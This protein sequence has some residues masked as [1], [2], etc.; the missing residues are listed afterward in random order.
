MAGV[1]VAVSLLSAAIAGWAYVQRN[2]AVAARDRALGLERAVFELNALSTE[3]LVHPNLRVRKQ[4]RQRHASL[5]ELVEAGPA[6][7]PIDP[8]TIREIRSRLQAMAGAF[9]LLSSLPSTVSDSLLVRSRRVLAGRLL[10]DSQA[11]VAIA[12]RYFIEIRQGAE[13][14]ERRLLLSLLALIAL[15]AVAFVISAMLIGR[16]VVR[17]VLQLSRSMSRM[18]EGDLEAP[19]ES[20]LGARNEVGA[21]IRE[22]DRTRIRLRDIL[23]QQTERVELLAHRDEELRRQTEELQRSNAELAQFAYVAS[24]DLRA[25]LR[26]INHLASW[27]ED[28]AGDNLPEKAKANLDL[29]KARVVRM[30]KLLTDLLAYSRAGR[31]AHDEEVVDT[32]ELVREAIEFADRPPGFTIDIAPGLPRIKTVRLPLLQVFGNL[33]SNAVKHHDRP[34]GRVEIGCRAEADGYVF[35]VADDGPGI[36]VADRERVFEMFRTL[37]RK[38]EV[39]GT[40]MGMALVQRLVERQ[41]GRIWIESGEGEA[42]TILRFYWPAKTIGEPGDGVAAEQG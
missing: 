22:V 9:E 40:G 26:G 30:D 18:G 34:D 32:Q 6:R 15:T 12:D 10:A 13:V 36:P 2:E 3:Y 16:D 29:L 33:I 14:S 35:S 11:V 37:R 31:A 21:L 38:D 5:M 19:I 4:W 1:V 8:Q 39:E 24:H 17:P 20:A 25:P 42:G 23:R 41:G 27:V 7:L 28:D